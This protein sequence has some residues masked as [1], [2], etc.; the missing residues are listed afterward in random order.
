MA[1]AFAEDLDWEDLDLFPSDALTVDQYYKYRDQY[2]NQVRNQQKLEEISPKFDPMAQVI[3]ANM[4][5]QVRTH[6]FEDPKTFA[7]LENDNVEEEITAVLRT[8]GIDSEN[9]NFRLNSENT[10]PNVGFTDKIF[11]AGLN[12]EY[13]TDEHLD[14]RPLLNEANRLP[15]KVRSTNL[16]YV[17]STSTSK[18]LLA[19]EEAEQIDDEYIERAKN[20][21]NQP[22]IGIDNMTIKVNRLT[23]QE[24]IDAASKN[25]STSM[26]SQKEPSNAKMTRTQLF[27]SRTKSFVK[28]LE[29]Y[30]EEKRA[31]QFGNS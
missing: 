24:L 3:V 12:G 15:S 19:K 14:Y 28:P 17:S 20:R 23:I 16:S 13:V 5:N 6:K 29:L 2:E 25:K 27:D 26:R 10:L 21:Y 31:K 11:I 22:T 9:P 7:G 30:F 8:T 1:M 4:V 18:S